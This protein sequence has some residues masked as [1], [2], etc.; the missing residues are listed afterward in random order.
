MRMGKILDTVNKVDVNLFYSP[1]LV[2][3]YI[4]DCQGIR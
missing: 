3:V 2:T 4:G 1:F